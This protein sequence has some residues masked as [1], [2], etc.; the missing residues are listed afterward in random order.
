MD[1]MGI[2]GSH[3]K[4]F[5]MYVFNQRYKFRRY[6]RCCLTNLSFDSS[7]YDDDHAMVIVTGCCLT[8]N[9]EENNGSGDDKQSS[10]NSNGSLSKTNKDPI[11]EKSVE[12]SN[13][14]YVPNAQIEA[15]LGFINIFLIRESTQI[16]ENGGLCGFMHC[17]LSEV[18]ALSRA[19]VLSLGGNA[20][21]SCKL[22]QCVLLNNPHRNQGQCLVNVSGD[23]VRV[24]RNSSA[25]GSP[26]FD[27]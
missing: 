3:N 21:V 11:D 24:V 23:A 10:T 13:L 7:L 17:F 19:H 25:N 22:N 20:L 16:K 1:L 15:Y 26:H 12:I 2:Y 18:L 14:S 6:P 9:D 4:V 27:I 8:Y 5:Y